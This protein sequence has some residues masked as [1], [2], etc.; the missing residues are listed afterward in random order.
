[1]VILGN[2]QFV[3]ESINLK[4]EMGFSKYLENEL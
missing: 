4:I 1:M 3:A 2:G